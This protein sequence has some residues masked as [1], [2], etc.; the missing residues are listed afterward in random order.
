MFYVNTAEFIE[1]WV[2]FLPVPLAEK[3]IGPR[4][5]QHQGPTFEK[6]R[7]NVE[8]VFSLRIPRRLW[9]IMKLSKEG[10]MIVVLPCKAA[11]P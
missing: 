9:V 1:L 11:R 5:D 3:P 8:M 2:A 6:E 4:R 10:I 7:S